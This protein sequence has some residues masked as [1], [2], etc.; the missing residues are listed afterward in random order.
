MKLAKK[1]VASEPVKSGGYKTPF[2]GINFEFNLSHVPQVA[3]LNGAFFDK[4][5][6]NKSKQV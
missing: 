5:C 4:V 6:S 3:V 1:A 2:K